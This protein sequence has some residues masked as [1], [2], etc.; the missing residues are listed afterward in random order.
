MA[1]KKPEIVEVLVPIDDPNEAIV[2]D[3]LNFEGDACSLATA[4]FE[5][6]L[7]KV[8]KKKL[9]PEF[10]KKKAKAQRNIKLGN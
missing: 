5:K 9:K 2:I 7:G 3:A 10:R 6:A 8:E 4:E 1:L